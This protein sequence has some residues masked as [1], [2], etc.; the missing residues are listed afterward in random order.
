[1]IIKEQVAPRIWATEDWAWRVQEVFAT[2][3]EARHFDLYH[4]QTH[5]GWSPTFEAAVTLIREYTD[6]E[7]AY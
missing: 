7:V 2:N 5:M 3:Q 4:H 6:E 1:M